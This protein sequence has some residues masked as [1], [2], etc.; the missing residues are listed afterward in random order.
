MLGNGVALL[1]IAAIKSE[2]FVGICLKGYGNGCNTVPK[3]AISM[4]INCAD[5]SKVGKQLYRLP[6]IY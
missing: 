6:S 5:K 2:S 4:A 3:D 1:L